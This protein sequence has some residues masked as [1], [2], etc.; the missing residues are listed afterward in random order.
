MASAPQLQAY[1]PLAL[2]HPPEALNQAMRRPGEQEE[3]KL[4]RYSETHV[5]E[6]SC[7]THREV[8]SPVGRLV[9]GLGRPCW[10]QDETLPRAGR[11]LITGHGPNAVLLLAPCALCAWPSVS[12]RTT[13]HSSCKQHTAREDVRY[14]VAR[15]D[16]K[17]LVPMGQFFTNVPSTIQPDTLAAS[18]KGHLQ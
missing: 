4:R 13:K 15:E 5:R 12:P 3:G 18:T 7:S 17:Y 9:S 6:T 16:V 10:E 1:L 2:P 11:G 14:L 8:T